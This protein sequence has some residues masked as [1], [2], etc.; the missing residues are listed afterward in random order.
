MNNEPSRRRLVPAGTEH[1]ALEAIVGRAILDP[2]FREV[3]L[4]APE[5]VQ[6]EYNLAD[7][8]VEALRQI[9]PSHLETF[10]DTLKASLL[11][12]AAVT[13]FCASERG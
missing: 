3:L 11:K 10:A 12:A 5:R 2:E 9:R 8:E 13:I 7:E 6:E 4:R 1:T